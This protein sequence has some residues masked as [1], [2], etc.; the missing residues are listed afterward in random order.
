MARNA[1]GAVPRISSYQHDP[2]PSRPAVP[3]TYDTRQDDKPKPTKAIAPNR[4]GMQL[5]KKPKATDM[6][7]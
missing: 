5:G 4:K 7:E 2:T 3:E 1:R 6:F